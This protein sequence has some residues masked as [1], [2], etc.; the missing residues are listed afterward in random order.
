MGS[1]LHTCRGAPCGAFAGELILHMSL[2]GNL[3]VFLTLDL[4]GLYF[5]HLF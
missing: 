1:G 4:N 3:Q 5:V 2:T